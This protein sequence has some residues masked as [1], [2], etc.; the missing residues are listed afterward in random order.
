MRQQTMSERVSW[1]WD[2]AWN[3]GDVDALDDVLAPTYQ[4]TSLLDERTL[5]R[6]GMKSVIVTVRESFPD[7][8]TTIERCVEAEDSMAVLWSSVGTHL[9]KF[10]DVPPT[11]KSVVTSGS[12]FFRARDGLI[13]EEIET[14][15][16]RD[17]LAALGIHSLRSTRDA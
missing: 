10:G 7:M 14:W 4:R 17:I 13:V 5:D 16:S 15:D 3:H 8:K 12:S 1:A 11:G 9:G 2:R 6:A